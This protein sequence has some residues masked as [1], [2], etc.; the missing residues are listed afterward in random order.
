MI[1]SPSVIDLAYPTIQHDKFINDT[2]KKSRRQTGHPHYRHP[3]LRVCYNILKC[4][5]RNPTRYQCVENF[6]TILAFS[7]SWVHNKN[8]FLFP[9]RGTQM[10]VSQLMQTLAILTEEKKQECREEFRALFCPSA[11]EG[12]PCASQGHCSESLTAIP[13]RQV[14][15]RYR[16]KSETD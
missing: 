3:L 9:E 6:P 2:F 13:H 11:A 4:V 15:S 10:R 14:Q 8:I 16:T 1:T 5:Q 7:I 12:E